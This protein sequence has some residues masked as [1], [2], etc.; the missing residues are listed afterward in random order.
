M[1]TVAKVVAQLVLPKATRRPH[2]P[3]RPLMLD[4]RTSSLKKK[5][6]DTPPAATQPAVSEPG[7]AAMAT[8]VD[9]SVA[10]AVEPSSGGMIVQTAEKWKLQWRTMG[11]TG[12]SLGGGQ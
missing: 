6:I 5:K 4:E 1:A 9:D 8:T 7:D 2:T 3:S 11:R 10:S 12:R